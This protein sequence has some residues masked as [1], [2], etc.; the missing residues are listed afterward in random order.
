MTPKTFADRISSFFR[1]GDPGTTP[2]DLPADPRV[3][4]KDTGEG[5]SFYEEDDPEPEVTPRHPD[6]RESTSRIQKFILYFIEPELEPET[7]YQVTPIPVKESPK[8]TP[9]VSFVQKISGAGCIH[10]ISWSK[11]VIVFHRTH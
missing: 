10:T 11:T 7:E 6:N 4:P 2:D 8:K 3:S 5:D 9:P 1:K